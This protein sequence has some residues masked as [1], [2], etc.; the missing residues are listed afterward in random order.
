MHSTIMMPSRPRLRPMQSLQ[1]INTT[2][3]IAPER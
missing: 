1:R 3:A 2:F